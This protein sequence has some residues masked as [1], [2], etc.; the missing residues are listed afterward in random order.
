MYTDIS[1]ADLEIIKEQ[2]KST[3]RF[4]KSSPSQFKLPIDCTSFLDEKTTPAQRYWYIKNNIT[5]P[6]LCRVCNINPT[7]WTG[8]KNG[9]GLTC[10]KECS[11]KDPHR[12][13]KI[14]K[15]N[16]QKY[17]GVAPACS[18]EIVKCQ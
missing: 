12:T 14:R 2:H 15:T 18:S 1:P 11:K 7:A 8:P 4:K 3:A 13:S 16:I 6:H 9:Y 5:E 17:G 10:S